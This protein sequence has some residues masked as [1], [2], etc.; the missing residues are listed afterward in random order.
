M[1]TKIH[2]CPFVSM[3]QRNQKTSGQPLFFS[4]LKG[5]QPE[6]NADSP[7]LTAE[8]SSYGQTRAG[9]AR[10]HTLFSKP[11]VHTLC[12]MCFCSPSNCSGREE[13]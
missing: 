10:R 9:S 2:H 1:P 12:P 7:A 3:G 8:A 5:Q 4:A 13:R 6:L 11:L